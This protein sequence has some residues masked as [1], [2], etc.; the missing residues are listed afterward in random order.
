VKTH[1][2]QPQPFKESEIPLIKQPKKHLLRKIKNE[3]NENELENIE[4]KASKPN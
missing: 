4:T 3:A 2:T 1:K